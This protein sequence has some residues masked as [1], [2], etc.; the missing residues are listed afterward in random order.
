MAKDEEI[1]FDNF[2]FDD[3]DDDFGL[4]ESQSKKPTTAREAA[5]NSLKDGVAGFTEDIAG[6]PLATAVELAEKSLP[7]SIRSE[8]MDVKDVAT[9]LRDE[10]KQ[11]TM[12]VRRAGTT[13]LKTI[14]SMM[15]DNSGMKNLLDKVV[16]YIGPD[17][18][19]DQRQEQISKEQAQNLEIQTGIIEA[20]GNLTPDARQ[21]ALRQQIE[22]NRSKSHQELMATTVSNGQ[23]LLDYTY[24]VTNN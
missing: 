16:N 6:D 10:V 15:P 1:D 11:A 22:L 18:S 14:G 24:N 8:V 2:D 20:L 23:K 4:G 17:D 3:M 19:Y 5:V 13:T 9:T 7:N 21:E 12:D